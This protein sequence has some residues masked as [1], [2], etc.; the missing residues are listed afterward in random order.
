MSLFDN[1]FK[2]ADI[3]TEVEKIKSIDGAMLL[4]V[5]DK[6]EYGAGHIPGSIN[7]PVKEIQNVI[8]SISDL[9]TPVFVYCLS[10]ARASR[11][12]QIM[13]TLGYTNVKNIGGISTYVGLKVM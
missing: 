7:I 3:N 1:I 2:K 4:D 11:A 12:V 8:E 10:G 9:N 6:D 13:K 5:R